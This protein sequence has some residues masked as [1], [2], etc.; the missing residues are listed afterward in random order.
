MLG[1]CRLKSIDQ[2]ATKFTR[3][4]VANSFWPLSCSALSWLLKEADSPDYTVT[5]GDAC[6]DR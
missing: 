6:E 4:S 3:I 2:L 5:T 1:P